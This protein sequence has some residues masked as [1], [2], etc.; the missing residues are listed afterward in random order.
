MQIVAQ[1]GDDLV[2]LTRGEIDLSEHQACVGECAFAMA[3]HIDGFRS[4][5][6]LSDESAG[7]GIACR[8]GVSIELQSFARF[9]FRFLEA[10]QQQKRERKTLVRFHAM[11]V[12]GECGFMLGQRFLMV[13]QLNETESQRVVSL[14]EI[15]INVQSFLE[16]IGGVL[17]IAVL[18][19]LASALVFFDGL[20]G[21]AQLADRNEIV[22]MRV[23]SCRT[24]LKIRANRTR[25]IDG[26]KGR[27]RRCIGSIDGMA[28]LLGAKNGTQA[29]QESNASD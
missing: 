20:R 6:A 24:G 8:D 28:F 7:Q 4:R 21:N 29:K 14:N 13:A 12:E 1:F 23:S 5:M 19:G 27:G 18:E 17:Q 16:M 3:Q 9:T 25:K 22:S 10:V 26:A 2:R 11:R 15:G